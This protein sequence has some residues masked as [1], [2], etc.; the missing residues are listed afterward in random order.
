VVERVEPVVLGGALMPMY[1]GLYA[2]CDDDGH[3][4]EWDVWGVYSPGRPPPRVSM[5]NYDATLCDP[6]DPPEC[7]PHY[8]EEGRK[9][10]P[11][12]VF[13]RH[14]EEIEEYFL[15]NPPEKPRRGED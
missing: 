9:R 12:D 11:D 7:E 10:V 2:W 5:R 14:A 3:E 13:A 4:H 6:G 8:A 15:A 1:L